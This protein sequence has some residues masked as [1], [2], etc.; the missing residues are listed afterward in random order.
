MHNVMFVR[1]TSIYCHNCMKFTKGYFIR[2]EMGRKK[3]F[4]SEIH[5]KEFC[6]VTKLFFN[7]CFSSYDYLKML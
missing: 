3:L 7:N 6:N 2:L 4:F 5:C 1:M